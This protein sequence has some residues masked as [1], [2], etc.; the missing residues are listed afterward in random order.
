M[1]VR[2]MLFLYR[3]L[4]HIPDGCRKSRN[5]H[6][7]HFT[8]IWQ[9]RC[10]VF[11]IVV[12]HNKHYQNQIIKGDNERNNYKDSD[13][14]KWLGNLISRFDAAMQMHFIRADIPYIDACDGQIK[15]VSD[16]FWL[17]NQIEIFTFYKTMDERKRTYLAD[18]TT[19][20]WWLRYPITGNTYYEYCVTTSGSS[21][22]YYSY[23][24]H[25][26]VPACLIG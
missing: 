12:V 2:L 21:N 10:D 15:I 25:G 13:I 22:Y 23:G 19:T 1:S 24:S 9:E 5:N 16:K 11:S 4:Q 20:N 17:L 8:K 6:L 26:C 3:I 14:R 7:K 18:N